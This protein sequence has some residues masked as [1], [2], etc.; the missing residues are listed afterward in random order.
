MG[1]VTVKTSFKMT[2]GGVIAELNHQED[3]LPQGSLLTSNQSG[4]AWS[5]KSRIVFSHAPK[6]KEF[7]NENCEAMFP[8]FSSAKK[9]LA[10]EKQIMEKERKGTFMYL[11]LPQGHEAIPVDNEAL[12]V[13]FTNIVLPEFEEEE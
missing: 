5:V 7:E 9:R 1:T 3:G 10:S 11:I 4:N 6:Q 13:D 2:E 8:S 12:A